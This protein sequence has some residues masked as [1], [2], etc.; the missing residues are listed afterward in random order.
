MITG[1]GFKRDRGIAWL[2]RF[3]LSKPGWH[4]SRIDRLDDTTVSAWR[5]I[6]LDSVLL[7]EIRVIVDR[8]WSHTLCARQ[9]IGSSRSCSM[10][11]ASRGTPTDYSTNRPL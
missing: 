8:L 10:M 1:L 2:R 7:I 3:W 11:S 9:L 5:D 4:P 6:V